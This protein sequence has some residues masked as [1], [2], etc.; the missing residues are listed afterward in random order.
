MA[1]GSVLT[2]DPVR[3]S[4]FWTGGKYGYMSVCKT[5]NNGFFWQRYNISEP[6]EGWAYDI[7]VD[8]GDPDIIYVGGIPDL[9]KTINAGITWE[10]ASIGIQGYVNDIE[11]DPQDTDILFAGTSDGIYKTTNG[12]VSWQHTGLNDVNAVVVDPLASDTI[13]AGTTAGIFKS[14]DQGY[15]WQTMGLDDEDIT[16]LK[17]DPGNYLFAGT[18]E[19]GMFRRYFDVSITETPHEIKIQALIKALPNPAKGLTTIQYHLPDM[20]RVSLEIYDIQGRLVKNLINDYQSPGRYAIPWDGS[21]NRNVAVSG[22]VY[23]YKFTVNEITVIQ[24][25]ILLK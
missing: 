2:A 18:N 21:D 3:D 13:Y 6:L 10:T 1:D 23:F 14:R 15:T 8:P 5:T 16:E 20:S 25:I 22:G 4:V 7:A 12:A 24:K 19:A 11:I 17:I 9:Y